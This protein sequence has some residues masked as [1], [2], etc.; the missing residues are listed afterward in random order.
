MVSPDI[1]YIISTHT[2][3]S[4]NTRRPK[5]APNYDVEYE[6]KCQGNWRT[7][8]SELHRNS[9]ETSKQYLVFKCPSAG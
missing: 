7:N 3:S 5:E 4:S 9:L 2:D 6:T 8:Y 1:Q